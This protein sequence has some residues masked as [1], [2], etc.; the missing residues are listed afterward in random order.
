MTGDLGLPASSSDTAS[1]TPRPRHPVPLTPHG[2]TFAVAA[3]PA[4]IMLLPLVV[5][6]IPLVGRPR[7]AEGA[8]R[9]ARVAVQGGTAV[10]FDRDV[11]GGVVAGTRQRQVEFDG[12]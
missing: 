9:E 7:S 6:G 11:D 2:A 8:A 5:S 12:V 4:F 10:L 3:G 1:P